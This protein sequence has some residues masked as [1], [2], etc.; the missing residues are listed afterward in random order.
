MPAIKVEQYLPLSDTRSTTRRMITENRLCYSIGDYNRDY[1]NGTSAAR[2][3]VILQ[4]KN[5]FVEPIPGIES[6]KL[7]SERFSPFIVD[8]TR[9]IRDDV[10]VHLDDA[11]KFLSSHGLSQRMVAI[12]LGLDPSVFSRI[13]RDASGEI[14]DIQFRVPIEAFPEL[15]YT[16]LGCTVTELLLGS[17]DAIPI[18]ASRD[19]QLLIDVYNRLDEQNKKECEA[20]LRALHEEQKEFDKEH[21]ED[22]NQKI[23][24]IAFERLYQIGDDMNS[25]LLTLGYTNGSTESKNRLVRVMQNK[26]IALYLNTFL[27]ICFQ[28]EISPD[29][30]LVQDYSSLDVLIRTNP[31]CGQEKIWDYKNEIIPQEAEP[32]SE[33]RVIEDHERK[34]LSY[35][36]R[37]S[38]ERQNKLLAFFVSKVV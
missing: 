15:A 21:P 34:V 1:F 33:W 16:Y 29:V 30:L 2:N 19:I 14:Q 32:D 9:R 8:T 35:Y 4:I 6:C 11:L 27:F 10:A 3:K 5:G 36:L 17:N 37:L 13:T 18:H 12:Q 31:F 20:Y 25:L 24:R 7:L 23:N 22:K 38:Q 26:R 28:F